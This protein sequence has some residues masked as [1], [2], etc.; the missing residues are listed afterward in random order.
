MCM[1]LTVAHVCC[2]Q[3]SFQRLHCDAQNA[4]EALAL[5]SPA[6]HLRSPELT[7]Q[8]YVLTD[9][10]HHSYMRKLTFGSSSSSAMRSYRSLLD[11][12]PA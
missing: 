4:V 8:L 11:P 5:I 7:V 1:T 10:L 12:Q 3:S 2:A 6:Q 9:T